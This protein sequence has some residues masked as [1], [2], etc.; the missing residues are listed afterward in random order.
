MRNP[1]ISLTY[2][3]LGHDDDAKKFFFFLNYTF[4]FSIH[5]ERVWWSINFLNI[6][7]AFHKNWTCCSLM[8]RWFVV[9]VYNSCFYFNQQ[10]RRSHSCVQ[11]NYINESNHFPLLNQTT[12]W[13]KINLISHCL[14]DISSYAIESIHWIDFRI[15]FSCW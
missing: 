2:C 10:F 12:K 5:F 4:F 7:L 11:F 3:I 13:K 6:C 8:S 14:L 9:I 1:T 15:F